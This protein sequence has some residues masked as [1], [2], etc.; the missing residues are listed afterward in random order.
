MA[1]DDSSAGGTFTTDPVA[2]AAW[3]EIG[4]VPP[5][6]LGS[7]LSKARSARGLTLSDLAE[8]ADGRFSLGQLAS[9]E[10]GTVSLNDDGLRNVV[11]LYG[12]EAGTLIPD[13][14]RLVVD[15]DEGL[16]RVADTE[17]R[18]DLSSL[19]PGATISSATRH[20]VLSRYLSMVYTMREMAPGSKLSLRVEDLDVLGT[21]LR[22]GTSA[23]NADLV[24]LMSEVDGSVAW[25]TQL[26]RRR[27]LIPAAGILVAFCGASALLMIQ[28]D[29]STPAGAET[30]TAVV[31]TAA[32]SSGAV[33]GPATVQVRNADGTPGPITD[34]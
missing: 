22:V 24:A 9:I 29:G 1:I 6:R 28:G 11:S 16:L 12:V 18:L 15:L 20:D 8:H 7:M 19:R 32:P 13:R 33:L 23:L 10:R 21:T 25:R 30:P 14:S 3:D 4:L 5:R 27:V 31:T 26:L 17:R 2:E 34:R